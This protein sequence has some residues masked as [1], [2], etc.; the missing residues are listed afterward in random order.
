[1][2]K[3]ELEN[4]KFIREKI[5]KKKK[6]KWE[7]AKNIFMVSVIAV[8]FGAVSGVTF[9]IVN[10]WMESMIS[11]KESEIDDVY[12]TLSIP[13]DESEQSEANQE[14]VASS[15]NVE[16]LVESVID[17]RQWSVEDYNSIN[18]AIYDV[19]SGVQKSFVTIN[20]DKEGVDWFDNVLEKQTETI[21]VVLQKTETDIFIMTSYEELKQATSVNITLK[22]GTKIPIKNKYADMQNDLAIISVDINAVPAALSDMLVPAALGNSNSLRLGNS[23][24]AV[25]S[26]MGHTY[27]MEYGY[28]SYIDRN[29]AD[30]DSTYKTIYTNMVAVRDSSGFLVNMK[31]EIVGWITN[32][33]KGTDTNLIE[34]MG[35]SD[36]KVVIEKMMNDTNI[37]YLGIVG[38]E[39]TKTIADSTGLPMGIYIE[40]IIVDSP[41]YVAGLQNGDIV[42]Q[43]GTTEIKTMAE[44]EKRLLQ[45]SPAENVVIKILREGKDESKQMDFTVTLG[46]R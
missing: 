18:Q 16:L 35:I 29:T 40:N 12:H 3:P 44:L 22:D 13:N 41:A 9:A 14:M 37:P 19:Y 38:K 21:G 27:S 4:S 25:G 15:E 39:I 20:I 32:R 11:P 33:F 45:Y 10:P 34:A 17:T 7:C 36:L 23:V 5:V 1:M 30:I 6:S 8:V 24:M 26:P 43:M 31:G 46:Q 28:I 2:K 42:L